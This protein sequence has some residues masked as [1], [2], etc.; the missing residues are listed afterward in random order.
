[1]GLRYHFSYFQSFLTFSM[2]LFLQNHNRSVIDYGNFKFD[3]SGKFFDLQAVLT[4][5]GCIGCI[6]FKWAENTN[7][8]SP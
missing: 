5:T 4:A 6:I 7:S 3:L 2:P 1:M 8:N